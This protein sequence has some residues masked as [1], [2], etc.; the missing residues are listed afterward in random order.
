MVALL[1]RLVLVT[2]LA[3]APA[4][5]ADAVAPT[6]RAALQELVT[7]ARLPNVTT[8]STAEIRANAD[9]LQAAFQR[10]GWSARQLADGETPM[11]FAEWGK[12][13][14]G[15]ATILFYAHMDGQPVRPAEW[16]QPD[17]FVPVLRQCADPG[18]CPMLPL[19]RLATGPIDPEWRLFGR[20]VADDK[21]PILMMIAAIDALRAR[22]EQP[23]IHVKMIVDS[24]EEGGPP[25]LKDVV[26][27]NAALLK[28][29]GLVMM[30]GPMHRSNR[31]T[32]VL[33]H[34]GGGV[35][36]ITVWG[37]RNTLHS[38]H[39]GNYAPNPAQR[40]AALVASFQDDAGHVVLPGYD[41][42][43]DPV[44]AASAARLTVDDDEPALLKTLGIAGPARADEPYRAAIM[45]PSLNIVGLGAGSM[46]AIDQSI[47]PDRAVAAFDIRTVPGI[48]FERQVGL[49]RQAIERAGYHLVEGAP[50]DDQ[51]ARYPQLATL[52]SRWL[53]DPLFTDIDTKLGAWGRRAL[54]PQ[55]VV[56]PI[57][58][59]SVPSAPL[60]EGLKLPAVLLPLVNADNN[61][62]AA[63]ENLRLGNFL[64]GV[65]ELETL[66]KTAFERHETQTLYI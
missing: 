7:F 59:G 1:H 50:S 24:H 41:D 57:M 31:P 5:A 34:R 10:H 55:S 33:G 28:A 35:A 29:D 64:T 37:P 43:V 25:T 49:V 42:G 62:H 22:G 51:R 3:A 60:V 12:A 39:Y 17:P 53:S 45:R 54:G 6:T 19:A 52:E 30:D 46:G 9:W 63:N 66:L 56:I 36:R 47:V 40:L 11:V 2:L 58:G 32:L 38:G 13:R 23:A 61:Q 20:S 44:F 8:R 18:A 14:P 15:V 16:A 48:T 27:R 65:E 4:L 21:A 26:T